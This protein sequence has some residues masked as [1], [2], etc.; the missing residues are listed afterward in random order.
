[1]VGRMQ[2]R[3]DE[4]TADARAASLMVKFVSQ[5]LSIQS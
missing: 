3:D 5:M 4:A 1:M 2:L